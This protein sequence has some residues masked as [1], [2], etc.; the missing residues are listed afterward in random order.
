LKQKRRKGTK[1]KNIQKYQQQQE[2][3]EQSDNEVPED[4]KAEPNSNAN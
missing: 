1:H 4:R 3:K 2:K